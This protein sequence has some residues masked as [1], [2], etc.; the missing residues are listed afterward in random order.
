MAGFVFSGIF[1][2]N[3][4]W[5]NHGSNGNFTELH[6]TNA[7]KRPANAGSQTA[8]MQFHSSFS[9]RIPM[10]LMLSFLVR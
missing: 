1:G 5:D 6:G 8:G 3:F 7:R 4:A 9:T 2:F 10:Y